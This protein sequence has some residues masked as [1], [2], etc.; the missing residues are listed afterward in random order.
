MDDINERYMRANEEYPAQLSRREGQNEARLAEIDKDKREL[1]ASQSSLKNQHEREKQE[2]E[3]QIRDEG[4][5]QR[6]ALKEKHAKQLAELRRA[7]QAEKE[8]EAEALRY[9]LEQNE[10]ALEEAFD[11][12]YREKDQKL[13]E[14]WAEQ[15]VRNSR[16][17]KSEIYKRLSGLI[18]HCHKNHKNPC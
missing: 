3:K 12:E 13:T 16:F 17:S 6:R 10:Q 9:K 18:T 2:I 7:Q 14:K 15:K 11:R 4:E 5:L 8:S 1:E